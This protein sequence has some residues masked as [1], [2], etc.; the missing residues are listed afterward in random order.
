MIFFRVMSHLSVGFILA[1]FLVSGCSL[2]ESSRRP[3]G[4][5]TPEEVA[6]G[7]TV[8]STVPKV[9]Y[10]DLVSKFE[11][12]QQENTKLKEKG[13]KV[14]VPEMEL[15]T[16]TPVPE[17]KK[18]IDPNLAETVD[19]FAAD[20]IEG[21]DIPTDLPVDAM[22]VLKK[23]D[24]IP[25]TSSDDEKLELEIIS[26]REGISLFKKREFSQAMKIF[27]QLERSKFSQI[28]VQAKYNIGDLLYD[29]G[30]FDLSLQVYED[31][32]KKFAFSGLV[33]KS[34]NKL[35][36]CS[37]KLGLDKKKAQYSS[38]LKDFFDVKVN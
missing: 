17:V 16:P 2:F 35:V 38:M 26:M 30:E 21:Y 25:I 1:L 23:G 27:Q 14:P 22:D 3:L 24:N 13:H 4:Q 9:Q 29:Q 33:I 11:A 18:S 15:L 5:P 8:V 10:D 20:K 31:V 28:V 32:I 19:V 12:L 34:L 7:K 37:E 36:L 6:Q